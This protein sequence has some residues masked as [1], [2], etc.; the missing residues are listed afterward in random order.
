MNCCTPGSWSEASAATAEWTFVEATLEELLA[1]D[2]LQQAVRSTGLTPEQ[3]RVLLRRY[4]N[5][6]KPPMN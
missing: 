4:A 3:F 1:D 5:R 2:V 6:M